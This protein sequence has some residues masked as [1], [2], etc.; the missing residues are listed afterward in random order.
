MVDESYRK[1]ALHLNYLPGGFPPSK[2]GAHIR[3]L[4]RLFTSDEAELATYLTLDQEESNIIADK[5]KLPRGKQKR[6]LTRWR[7][8]G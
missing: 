7:K 2:T 5:A 6:N 4:Q 8:R 1:L 3:L